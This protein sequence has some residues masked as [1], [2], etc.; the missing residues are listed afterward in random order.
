MQGPI[1]ELPDLQHEED[2]AI[3]VVSDSWISTPFGI[4]KQVLQECASSTKAKD[5]IRGFAQ[6]T[7]IMLAHWNVFEAMPKAPYDIACV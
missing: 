7:I 2:S 4:T 1:D 6:K 3:E 5:N